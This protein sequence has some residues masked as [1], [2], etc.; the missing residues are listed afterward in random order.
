MSISI[1]QETEQDHN[2]VYEIIAEAF[3]NKPHSDGSEPELVN[4]LRKSDAFIPELSLVAEFDGKLVG[5]LLLTKVTIKNVTQEFESLALA[6]VSVH[7]ELQG[8]GIGA[9]LIHAAHQKAKELRHNSVVLL[10]HED[11][12]PRFGY[13]AAEE[14]G[15]TFTFEAPSENCMA[16]EL[17]P[18][19]LDGVSGEVV[20]PKEFFG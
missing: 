11:Y 17:S 6:P 19:A 9:A 5:H 14:F 1:R 18:H 4:R 10:G 20:Y 2:T 13:N 12:Y 8:R 7:P 16:V 3:A 15:I